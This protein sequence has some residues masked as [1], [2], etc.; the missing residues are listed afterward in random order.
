M[1]YFVW[2]HGIHGLL[3]SQ[4]IICKHHLDAMMSKAEINVVL[5]KLGGMCLVERWK[6][7][8]KMIVPSCLSDLFICVANFLWMEFNSTFSKQDWHSSGIAN[9]TWFSCSQGKAFFVKKCCINCVVTLHL[10]R[11]LWLLSL[12][13]NKKHQHAQIWLQW[14]GKLHDIQVS[15]WSWGMGFWPLRFSKD[16]NLIPKIFNWR[17]KLSLNEVYFTEN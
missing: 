17:V 15:I 12:A 7:H 16:P 11:C 9:E 4:I 6:V 14:T 1:V 5:T 3:T 8:M 10:L 13:C 2:N